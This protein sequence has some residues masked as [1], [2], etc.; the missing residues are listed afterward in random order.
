V[1]IVGTLGVKVKNYQKFS[2]APGK[3]K[4]NWNLKS[5]KENFYAK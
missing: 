2:K 1:N 4:Q 3:T 5:Y